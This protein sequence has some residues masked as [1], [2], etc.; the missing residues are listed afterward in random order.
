MIFSIKCS[1]CKNPIDNRESYVHLGLRVV[2][3]L[4]HLCCYMTHRNSEK[5][6]A[7]EASSTKQKKEEKSEDISMIFMNP[8]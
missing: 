1:H 6:F 5:A 8:R 3:K 2:P 7:D 4:Y